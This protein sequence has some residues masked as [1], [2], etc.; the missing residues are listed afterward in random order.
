MSSL[1]AAKV[2]QETWFHM[3]HHGEVV[4]VY[5]HLC[6]DQGWAALGGCNRDPDVETLNWRP[7]KSLRLQIKWTQC[8]SGSLVHNPWPSGFA[9]TKCIFLLRI[10]I[11]FPGNTQRLQSRFLRFSSLFSTRGHCRAEQ[12]WL[13]K[14]GDFFPFLKC[15]RHLDTIISTRIVSSINLLLK[16]TRMP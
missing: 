4:V 10:S 16:N 8:F 5:P 12:A 3:Q 11:K 15:S 14:L 1:A 9:R 6:V 13:Q 7:P 2:K